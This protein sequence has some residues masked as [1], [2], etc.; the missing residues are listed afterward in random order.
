MMR[1][2]AHAPRFGPSRG[3]R[4]VRAKMTMKPLA[5]AYDELHR[6]WRAEDTRGQ[7]S[8]E[9]LLLGQ[10]AVSNV[11][12]IRT[13][14][15]HLLAYLKGTRTM[16]GLESLFLT[17]L[18]GLWLAGD[19]TMFYSGLK[20]WSGLNELSREDRSV[21]SRTPI[22]FYD[23]GHDLAT[24]V[25]PSRWNRI[26]D[27]LLHGA[28]GSGVGIGIRQG[29]PG[30]ASDGVLDWISCVGSLTT[31]G[32]AAGGAIGA[33]IGSAAGG[34]GAL[35][36]G[37]AGGIIG[38]AGGL[39]FGI[40]FCTVIILDNASQEEPPKEEGPPISEGDPNGGGTES[41]A[42][43]GSSGEGGTTTVAGGGDEG[44]GDSGS[45]D[46]GPDPKEAE[47]GDETETALVYPV[48][49]DLRGMG[50]RFAELVSTPNPDDD[51]GLP[52][53][54]PGGPPPGP[55]PVLRGAATFALHGM[56]RVGSAGNVVRAGFM[57]LALSG[58]RSV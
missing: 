32:A 43:G 58:M 5:T 12:G 42:Q 29:G 13:A 27:A 8:R 33:G 9:A 28:L 22:L 56:P 52:K 11:T 54:G 6:A 45:N 16:G 48:P 36:G 55:N 19:R 50:S 7:R 46:D 37:A 41:G 26:N 25:T 47:T 14:F 23:R 39:S 51:T 1:Q 49:D 2:I 57:G 24:F 53:G 34:V 15:G 35:P 18:H 40:G 4:F 10:F 20:V 21:E 38:G 30:L 17:G 44:G 3:L 31:M